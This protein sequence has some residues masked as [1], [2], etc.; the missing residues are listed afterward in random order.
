MLWVEKLVWGL[1]EKRHIK[2]NNNLMENVKKLR[3]LCSLTVDWEFFFYY[4]RSRHKPGA[5]FGG[6]VWWVGNHLSAALFKC[7]DR[8]FMPYLGRVGSEFETWCYKLSRVL[9]L[10]ILH[11]FGCNFIYFLVLQLIVKTMRYSIKN[12]CYQC[13]INKRPEENY[14]HFSF[15]GSKLFLCRCCIK[16]QWLIFAEQVPCGLSG[17]GNKLQNS[18]IKLRFTG[19]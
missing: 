10:G 11:S 14:L 15:C 16:S 8:K 4:R 17:R 1:K 18:S 7:I 6:H 9:Y 19:E 2:I 5:N 13:S 12:N 3:K